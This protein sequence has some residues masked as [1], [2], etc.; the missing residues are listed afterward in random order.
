MHKRRLTLILTCAAAI[1]SAAVAQEITPP[2][3]GSA[4]ALQPA[5]MNAGE[6]KTYRIETLV[7]S[8]LPGGKPPEHSQR[9][10][11]IEVVRAGADGLILVYSQMSNQG[12]AYPRLAEVMRGRQIQ[13]EADA[14]GFPIRVLNWSGQKAAM[15]AALEKNGGESLIPALRDLSEDDAIEGVLGDV[16]LVTAMQSFAPMERPKIEQVRNESAG[17]RV[18]SAQEFEGSRASDCTFVMKLT[19]EIDPTSPVVREARAT[20]RLETRAFVSM[21]DGW[22][23]EL[24]E[25]ARRTQGPGVETVLRKVTRQGP[26]QGACELRAVQPKG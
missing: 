14:S 25:T 3:A 13:F 16:T 12:S 21:A 20:D 26:K 4:I 18:L 8:T 1:A 15:I 10:F 17:L 19:T 24:N 23:V 5:V 9:I 11:R 7:T 22:V 6:E 2:P